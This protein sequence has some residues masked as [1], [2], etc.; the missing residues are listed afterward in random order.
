MMLVYKPKFSI[1]RLENMVFIYIVGVKLYTSYGS[2]MR[3]L[4]E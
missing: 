2:V 3:E 4:E 1:C